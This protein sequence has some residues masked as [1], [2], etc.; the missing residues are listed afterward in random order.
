MAEPT[1]ESSS[2]R[3]SSTTK[4]KIKEKMDVSEVRVM[5]QQWIEAV[6]K[7][8]DVTIALKGQS[9]IVPARAFQSGLKVELEGEGD[10]F[11]FEIKLK[12][13]E[14]SESKVLPQ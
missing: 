10:E 14:N 12:W 7:N 5:L 1:T 13:R 3:A 2:E 4:T 6:E 8:K 9:F 11:E